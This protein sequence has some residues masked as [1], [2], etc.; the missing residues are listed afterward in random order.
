MAPRTIKRASTA[1][2][3]LK[4][5]YPLPPFLLIE[6]F[7]CRRDEAEEGID[8]GSVHVV[9]VIF[10]AARLLSLLQT[11]KSGTSSTSAGKG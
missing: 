6:E 9:C 2:T 5:L 8:E 4:P 10:A 7:E 11:L 3:W 1:Q